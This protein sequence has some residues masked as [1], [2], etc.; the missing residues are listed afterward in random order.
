MNDDG[1]RRR[2]KEQMH[3]WCIWM[4]DSTM[5]EQGHGGGHGSNSVSQCKACCV[6]FVFD[7]TRFNAIARIWQPKL[8]P[9]A[10]SS[11]CIGDH[12][13]C[14]Q[15]TPAVWGG[16]GMFCAHWDVYCT[17]IPLVICMNVGNYTAKNKQ[18]ITYNSCSLACNGWNRTHMGYQIE[19]KGI[20]DS[21]SRLDLP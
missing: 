4:E 15:I 17:N 14:P 10:A 7:A 20:S 3:C 6:T 8:R 16:C 19:A 21:K 9:F 18:N 1:R 13:A 2:C 11:N 5:Q 12:P